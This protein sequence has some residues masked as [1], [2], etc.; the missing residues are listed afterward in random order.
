MIKAPDAG[1][2][3]SDLQRRGTKAASKEGADKEAVEGVEGESATA[4][5]T[6]TAAATEQ[7]RRE[8]KEALKDS[9]EKLGRTLFL[10]NLPIT[11]CTDKVTRLV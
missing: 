9:P 2:I 10:G 4:V 7:S 1:Q 11:I 5:D 6:A 8:K 3:I